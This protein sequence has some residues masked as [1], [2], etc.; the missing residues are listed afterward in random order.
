MR[1]V[2]FGTPQF[3]ATILEYLIA[4]SVDIVAVV[5]RPDKPKGRSGQPQ[6]TQVKEEASKHGIP[7]YQPRKASDPEFVDLLKSLN[8]DLFIVA[9]Y[10]EILRENVLE[11]PRLGCINVH[12]SI[13]PKYR[14]A[15][16][17]QRALMAGE[18]ETG[19]SIMKMALE[20]DAG[21]VY[22]FV[23]IPIPEEMTA[24]EL[25]D[26]MASVGAKALWD[27][28]QK[29]EK[30]DIEAKPQDHSQATFAKKV[31]PEDGEI[32][33][34]RTAW[35]IHNQIRGLTPNPGAWCW[36]DVRGAKKRMSVKKARAVPEHS[37]KPGTLIP[38]KSRLVI[39]CGKGALELLEVQLEGKKALPAEVFLR[40]M[41]VSNIKF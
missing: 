2:F 19:V 21:D 15:A 11:I 20:M 40:G 1:V 13:L 10:A 36:L 23:K 22:S 39:N 32:D 17:V 27:V 4:Q 14:G 31:K 41:D 29:V 25:F 26:E 16:P 5:S 12:G 7:V 24:G 30:G 37:G 35:E 34:S 18:K 6:P 3:A 33:W 8:P 28:M 38:T 9:A